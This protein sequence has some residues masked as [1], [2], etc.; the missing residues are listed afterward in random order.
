[1]ITVN[2]LYGPKNKLVQ[3]VENK[4]VNRGS[5]HERYFDVTF[6]NIGTY[7]AINFRTE[8]TLVRNVIEPGQESQRITIISQFYDGEE[9]IN[10]IEILI[11]FQDLEGN[12]YKQEYP[13]SFI[14]QL[15]FE[16]LETYNTYPELIG[17]KK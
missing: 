17:E 16:K 3:S 12:M 6:K 7:S 2:S 10:T 4:G 5:V 14:G 8:D 1:M 15:E 11:C 9:S 13:I